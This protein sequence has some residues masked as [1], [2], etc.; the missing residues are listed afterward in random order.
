V[1]T[2]NGRF[3]FGLRSLFVV[4]T[5][6]AGLLSLA[7]TAPVVFL[8]LICFFGFLLAI[9]AS[10]VAWGFVSIGAADLVCGI[11][12]H[13]CRWCRSGERLHPASMKGTSG[14]AAER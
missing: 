5:A 11:V 9:I 12:G 8:V 10:V 14:R 3:Q 4:T 13:A 7:V 1:A 2:D 6:F